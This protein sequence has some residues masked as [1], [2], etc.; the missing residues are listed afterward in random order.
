MNS[1]KEYQNE[2]FSIYQILVNRISVN[3]ALNNIFSSIKN[4]CIIDITLN[5]IYSEVYIN[6]AISVK[7]ELESKY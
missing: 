7:T 2:H 6:N 4:K 3:E 1:S 5:N